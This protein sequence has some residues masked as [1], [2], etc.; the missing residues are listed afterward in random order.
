[1]IIKEEELSKYLAKWVRILRLER[2]DIRIKIKRAED[3]HLE[4]CAGENHF[5]T[6][7]RQSLIN[8]R[9][10]VDW[11]NNDFEQDMELTLVHELLHISFTMLDTDNALRDKIQHQLLNDMAVALIRADRKEGS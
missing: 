5:T 7:S 10:P 11:T 6:T 9:D 3:M 1:M 4:E 2:W 8:L